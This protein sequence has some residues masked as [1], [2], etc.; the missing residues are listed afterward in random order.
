MKK[1]QAFFKNLFLFLDIDFK[2][3]F[4]S[5][6]FIILLLSCKFWHYKYA[7]YHSISLIGF[8]FS[9][10]KAFKQ[11]M[12]RL[13]IEGIDKKDADIPELFVKEGIDANE[14]YLVKKK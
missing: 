13:S 7:F 12:A 1:Y 11:A 10:D 14:I 8:G 9:L 2:L 6:F 3:F 5:F 4:I